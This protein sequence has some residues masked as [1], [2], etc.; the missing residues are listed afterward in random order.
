MSV[1]ILA[2]AIAAVLLFGCTKPSQYSEV[3]MV[4]LD[5]NTSCRIT[6]RGDGFRILVNYTEY[7]FIP[8]RGRSHQACRDNLI[9][10]AED[11]ALEKKRKIVEIEEN[12]IRVDS[13]RN[14]L[15]GN[16]TCTATYK[17]NW[18]KAK[19]TS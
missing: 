6:N 11:H 7:Q 10:I 1:Q 13:G 3:G 19:P 4:E 8:R 5:D 17:V 14:A 15:S 2:V 9:R 12:L 18:A 16:T